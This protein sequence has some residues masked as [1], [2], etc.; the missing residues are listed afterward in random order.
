MLAAEDLNLTRF[1]AGFPQ[2]R[3]A[4]ANMSDTCPG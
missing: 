3:T 2:I 4:A 1:I